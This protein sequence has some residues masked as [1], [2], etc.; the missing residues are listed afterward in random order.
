[1]PV[2]IQTIVAREILDSRG[3]PTV[4]VEVTLDNKIKAKASVASGASTGEFEALELRDG[5]ERRY[6]GNGVLKACENVN[7]K[8]APILIGQNV[9]AQKKIDT[10]MLKLDGTENKSELG[11]NAILGVSMACARAAAKSSK[12]SLYKYI[13]KAYGFDG[14]FK[15]PVPMFNILNGGK[16]ADSGLSIQEF[17]IVPVGIENIKDRVRAGSE[18]FHS[19]KKILASGGY[20]TGVGDEGGFAPRLGSIEEGIDSILKAVEQSGYVAGKDVFISLDAAANSFYFAK[21]EKYVVNPGNACLDATQLIALYLEWI[22]KYSLLSIEDG[23]DE[24]DW[25]GWKDMKKKFLGAKKKFIVV[26]D[27]LTVTNPKRVEMAEKDNC[28]NG[29]IIKLNQIGSLTETVE[30]IQKAQSLGWKIIISHRSG[31]T[32]DDFIADLAVA[33]GAEFIKSG[34]LSRGER[35]AKY[36]R[37]MEIEGEL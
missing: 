23:L 24:N 18:I 10:M 13:A 1:M 19:F 37:L 25:K 2:K 7:K 20:G 4:E 22:K 28:A 16:H 33:S 11:A 26:A 14:N 17:M 6:G 12:K 34:S 21:E 30:C 5:D 32:C 15:M 8:I 29:I 35:L 27:D 31:E 3:N 9:N 36:N